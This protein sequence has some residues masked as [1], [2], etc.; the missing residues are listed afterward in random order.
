MKPL[1]WQSHFRTAKD[2]VLWTTEYKLEALTAIC[3]MVGI[4]RMRR[5]S[6]RFRS[7]PLV[8]SSLGSSQYNFYT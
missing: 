4:I 7:Y 3:E 2:L 5:G 6:Y 1:H 8:R